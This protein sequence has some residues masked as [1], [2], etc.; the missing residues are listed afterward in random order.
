MIY[1]IK[2]V[3]EGQ[4]LLKEKYPHIS[5][6]QSTVLAQKYGHYFHN[7]MNFTD[8][9]CSGE[10]LD[11]TLYDWC[12]HQRAQQP[13][14]NTI[15]PCT[16]CCC[17]FTSVQRSTD[18]HQIHYRETDVTRLLALANATVL[19]VT[20]EQSK[21]CESILSMLILFPIRGKK[22]C[23]HITCCQHLLCVPPDRWWITDDS[24]ENGFTPTVFLIDISLTWL[25]A[26]CKNIRIFVTVLRMKN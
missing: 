12:H 16:A 2:H 11:H 3:M 5:G 24:V 14:W 26:T 8:F 9:K 22:R 17:R 1:V 15:I 6:L 13:A 20:F 23:M 25:C 18:H 10:S 7:Q 4:S 21:K 19:C